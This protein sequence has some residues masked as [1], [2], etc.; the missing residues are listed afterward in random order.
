MS[1]IPNFLIEML[2]KQYNKIEVDKIIEGYKAKRKVTLRVNNLKTDLN[3][4]KNEFDKLGIKYETVKFYE[5]ALIIDNA[6]KKDLQVL[7]MYEKGEIY[8]QSLSSML[9]P[10]VL[11]PQ[12]NMDIL[13]MCAAPRGKD[14]RISC[15]FKQ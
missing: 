1:N 14:H 15:Y 7:E 3:T 9:P 12:P 2:N 10:I 6:S 5:N 13:D 11:N 4:I 8:L